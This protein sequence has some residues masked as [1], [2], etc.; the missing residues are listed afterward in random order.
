VSRFGE[1]G[2]FSASAAFLRLRIDNSIVAA[3]TVPFGIVTILP[4]L[5]GLV[6]TEHCSITLLWPRARLFA[7]VST[8][9]LAFGYYPIVVTHSE[10][11]MRSV[12]SLNDYCPDS[13]S[14]I[15]YRCW[16]IGVT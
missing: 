4:S 16:L 11:L 3:T 15:V 8:V 5:R 6:E 7:G 2:D 10:P 9:T 13:N 1:E 12:I 14:L